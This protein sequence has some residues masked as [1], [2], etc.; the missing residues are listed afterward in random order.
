MPKNHITNLI[1]LF[2]KLSEKVD[3]QIKFYFFSKLTGN[4]TQIWAATEIVPELAARQYGL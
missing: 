4:W 2:F 3:I 1:P